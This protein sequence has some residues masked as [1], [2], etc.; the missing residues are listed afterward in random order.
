MNTKYIHITTVDNSPPQKVAHADTAEYDD[1][2]P[3]AQGNTPTKTHTLP[4]HHRQ[5]TERGVVIS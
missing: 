2:K 4:S 3:D 1:M 5:H